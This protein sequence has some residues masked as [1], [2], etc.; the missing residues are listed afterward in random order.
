[1]FDIFLQKALDKHGVI[2]YTKTAKCLIK[3]DFAAALKNAAKGLV[4]MKSGNLLAITAEK[5]LRPAGF[6]SES[7]R[8][9]RSERKILTAR[10][11]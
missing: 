8:E 3:S 7:Y 11:L 2:C 10:S 4:L 1:M 5:V 9:I 6:F